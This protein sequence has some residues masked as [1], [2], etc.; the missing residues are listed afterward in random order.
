MTTAPVRKFE[1]AR[2]VTSVY[3]CGPN[4]RRCAAWPHNARKL[5]KVPPQEVGRPPDDGRTIDVRL[6]PRDSLRR[7]I[8]ATEEPSRKGGV[9]LRTIWI[10]EWVRFLPSQ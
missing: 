7:F 5:E 1:N 3:R 4:R 8:I 10:D 6:R 2:P 9:P